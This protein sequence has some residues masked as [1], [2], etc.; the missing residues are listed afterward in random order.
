MCP[1][2]V[3]QSKCLVLI[4]PNTGDRENHTHV[5]VC[6]FTDICMAVCLC[7]SVCAQA[8]VYQRKK[9]GEERKETSV[10]LILSNF[11]VLMFCFGCV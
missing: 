5:K 10:S 6:E 9:G 11:C 8:C 1:S 7:V 2:V 4:E 3:T